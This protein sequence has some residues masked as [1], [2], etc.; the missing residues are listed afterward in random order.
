VL[1]PPL[2]IGLPLLLVATVGPTTGL[3]PLFEPRMGIKPTTTERTPPPR[4]HT[5]LLQ[6]TAWG[7]RN[8]RG[9]EEKRKKQ[10]A[11]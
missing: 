1:G 4:G 2:L 11:S 7:E 8:R 10:L 5:F 9:A 6:R 3:L